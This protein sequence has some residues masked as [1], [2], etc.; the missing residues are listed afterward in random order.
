[1]SDETPDNRY[2]GMG[3]ANQASNIS[4]GGDFKQINEGNTYIGEQSINQDVD[5]FPV[6]DPT[7]LNDRINLI[8]GLLSIIPLTEQAVEKI[9]GIFGVVGGAVF[10]GFIYLAVSDSSPLNGLA[11]RIPAV[12]WILGLSI[13][14]IL[15]AVG[16]FATRSEASCP[17]CGSSWALRNVESLETDRV[18]RQDKEDIRRVENR[19][20]CMNCGFETKRFWSSE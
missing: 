5:T 19:R 16:F 14:L 3:N 9:L 10:S 7:F 12:K 13:L 4:A 2:Q 18:I 15:G 6:N 11:V 17:E 8:T 20:R 1:M